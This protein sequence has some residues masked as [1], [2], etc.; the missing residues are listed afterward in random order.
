MQNISSCFEIIAICIRYHNI[1]ESYNQT[2]FKIL[3]NGKK[4]A[5]KRNFNRIAYTDHYKEFLNS[6]CT[7]FCFPSNSNLYTSY[8]SLLPVLLK[9]NISDLSSVFL[10]QATFTPVAV[11]GCGLEKVKAQKPFIAF[12]IISHI[13]YIF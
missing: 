7:S 6:N 2:S 4:E 12:T 5:R 9:G 3:L 13:L 10:T 1:L 8:Y 11:F